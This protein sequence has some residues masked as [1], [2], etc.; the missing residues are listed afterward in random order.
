MM[1]NKSSRTVQLVRSTTAISATALAMVAVALLLWTTADVLLLLFAGGLVAVFLGRLAQELS[2]RSRVREGWALTLVLVMGLVG[3]LWLM[4]ALAPGVGDE[5]SQLRRKL[6]EAFDRLKGDLERYDWANKILD[7]APSRRQLLGSRSDLFERVT[8][9]FSTTLG[10]LTSVIVVLFFGLFIAV[11]PRLYRSGF[12]HL[13]DPDLQHRAG[14]LL[15]AVIDTLWWWLLAKIASMMVVGGLTWIGLWALGIPLAFTLALL[16]AL[17]TF[18]PNIGPV[19]SAIPAM[20]LAVLESPTHALWVALLFLAIQTVESYL[21]TPVFQQKAIS[22][23]PALVIA[24]QVIMGVISG[25]I[26]LIVAT[27]LTAACYV[28]VKQIYVRDVLGHPLRARPTEQ[29]D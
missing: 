24:A 22:L 11:D 9:V 2:R 16:A 23:P 1:A 5:I 18:I 8:G 19:L 25:G 14:Q 15:D 6:P 13:F 27:P 17:L 7:E 21:I 26:G 12:L 28:L 10:A 20:L 29:G 4:W 3:S